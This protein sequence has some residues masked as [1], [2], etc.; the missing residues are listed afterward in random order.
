MFLL[1]GMLINPLMFNNY[2]RMM[3]TGK[4]FSPRVIFLFYTGPFFYKF[5]F[6]CNQHEKMAISRSSF[7]G[8][9]FF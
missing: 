8:F 7:C 4:T 9:I 6:N 5:R 2:N 1:K 3:F